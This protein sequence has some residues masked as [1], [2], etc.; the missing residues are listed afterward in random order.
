MENQNS[1]NP[2]TKALPSIREQSSSSGGTVIPFPSVSVQSM[3]AVKERSTTS[4]NTDSPTE[5]SGT[6]EHLSA[7]LEALRQA[8]LRQK[9]AKGISGLRVSGSWV[10]LAIEGIGLFL[11]GIIV[12]IGLHTV[13][14]AMLG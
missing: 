7:A 4:Q 3:S 1:I 9:K 6:P 11:L 13:F 5:Q 12:G 2:N 14:T 10:I 8:K